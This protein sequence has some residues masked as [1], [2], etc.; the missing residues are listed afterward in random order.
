MAARVVSIVVMAA[1]VV[2]TFLPATGFAFLNWDDQAVI[3]QNPS[4]GFPGA[5]TWAF[6]TTYMEH[7]QPLSW[8][9]WAALKTRAGLDA[10]VFHAA[11]VLAHLV[12]VALVWGVSRRVLSRS[13]PDLPGPWHDRA[14]LAAALLYGLHPLRVEA[15][16]WISALPYTLALA[17]MLAS[18]LAYMEGPA[19]AGHHI[20]VTEG[21][22][23][24]WP[25]WV[26]SLMLYAASLGARPVA[27]GFPIVLLAVDAGLLKRGRRASLARVSPF[28]VLA[29]AAAVIESVA[30]VPGLN[31][32][33]WLYRLQSAASAPFVYLWHTAAPIALTPLA[34]L[35]I[36][37]VAHSGVLVAAL[38]SL[39]A[40]SFAAWTWRHR[41][42]GLSAA[43]VAYLALLA[44]AAGLV[45][46]GLQ[47]TAD[48]YTYLPG[49]VVAIVVAGAA[50]RW[51]ARRQGRARLVTTAFVVLAVASSLASRQ[52][53]AWWS[54]SVSLWTRVV[55]L[56]PTHDVGLYNL[57]TALAAEGRN[58]EAAVRY[59]QVLALR[60]DHADARANLDRLDAARLER[61][62]NDLAARGDLTGAAERY[63]QAVALDPQRTHSQAS[64]GMALASLGR[65]SEALPVLREAIRLGVVDDP[66]VPSALG[67][68]LLQSGQTREA[69]SV[70][71][72]AL[73]K[74][75]NDVGLAHNL[76][77]LLATGRVIEP[78]DAMLALRLAGAVVAATGERDPR[79]L[80]TL[81]TALAAN[82]RR[83]EAM[84]VNAK[85][86]SLATALGD[87]DLAVQITARGAEYRRPGQ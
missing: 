49:V 44:P 60:P 23:A 53:L 42:P 52:A 78:R 9:V 3:V 55:T 11:N 62:G 1:A 12:C 77:R 68:L 47:V 76:A 33:P 6:T 67:V 21:P 34:V 64:L 70:F 85:A 13:A 45:P 61:Q 59:R 18:L 87:H 32:T 17:L 2:W 8:L 25:W 58:E 43:W 19:K 48:R 74:H 39:A 36:E 30:R 4:L 20:S 26:A 66:A 31:D 22:H 81:A 65:V 14:A 28:A 7:Y 41:W 51:A 37:P 10:T 63:R 16:A 5:A 82:G 38:L 73:A 75:Q 79:A 83:A 57:G 24:S 80:E 72:T 27:L 56:D 50:A 84:M 15:V 69:R 46:S 35:P 71:E 40:A 29:I 86:A 54:D